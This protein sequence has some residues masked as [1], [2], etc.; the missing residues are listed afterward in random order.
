MS[1]KSCKLKHQDTT[2]NLLKSQITNTTSSICDNVMKQ[3]LIHLVRMQNGT[4]MLE[5]TTEVFTKLSIFISYNAVITQHSL[6]PKELKS[7][8]HTK[9]L[10]TIVYS[11]SNS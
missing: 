10:C 4:V 1:L 6:Y 9:K 3:I 5:E 7:H 8:V 11:R 2:M